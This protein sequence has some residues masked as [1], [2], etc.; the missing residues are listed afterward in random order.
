[1]RSRPT[2]HREGAVSPSPLNAPNPVL[3]DALK[4]RDQSS[5]IAANWDVVVSSRRTQTVWAITQPWTTLAKMY[6]NLNLHQKQETYL[7]LMQSQMPR[8]S[9][10]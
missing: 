5:A 8:V 7:C 10:V 9:E 1:V 4:E 6:H 2:G 3:L